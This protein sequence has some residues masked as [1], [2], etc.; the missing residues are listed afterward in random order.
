MESNCVTEIL[1]LVR[2]KYEID[3]QY[4]WSE[5]SATYFR[6]L[7]KEVD[8]VE[9]ELEANRKCYLEDEL[10]DVLWDYLNLLHNLE[11]ERKITLSAV[12]DRSLKKYEERIDVISGGGL[13]APVK[14]SQKK[15]LAEEQ[16]KL[17]AEKKNK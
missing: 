7:K 17:D 4:D 6:E 13:W 3:Q 15:R 10:G 8:E 16:A 1:N 12:F 14:E 11:A 9:D 2:K 5:G